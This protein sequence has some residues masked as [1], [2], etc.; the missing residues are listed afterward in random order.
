MGYMDFDQRLDRALTNNIVKGKAVAIL[1][2]P[3]HEPDEREIARGVCAVAELLKAIS[4][5]DIIVSYAI[6]EWTH[7]RT[8]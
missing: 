8:A 4:C 2:K 6:A 7:D 5:G 3:D 1:S